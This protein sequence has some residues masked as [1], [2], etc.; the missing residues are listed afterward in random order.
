VKN[1]EKKYAD[2]SRDMQIAAEEIQLKRY[3]WLATF[4]N[5]GFGYKQLVAP[6]KINLIK[7]PHK[8]Q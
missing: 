3:E 7:Y 6:F 1:Y 5:D 8:Q 4:W 2:R